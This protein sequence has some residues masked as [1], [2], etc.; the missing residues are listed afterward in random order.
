MTAIASGGDGRRYRAQRTDIAGYAR[1]LR[2]RIVW[3]LLPVLVLGL[4]VVLLALVGPT[5][6]LSQY[7]ATARVIRDTTT[8]EAAVLPRIDIDLGFDRGQVLS[9]VSLAESDAVLNQVAQHPDVS[10]ADLQDGS[11]AIDEDSFAEVLTFT[12]RADTA[13]QAALI[14]NTWAEAYVDLKQMTARQAIDDVLAELDVELTELRAERSRITQRLTPLEAELEETVDPLEQSRL[15]TALDSETRTIAADVAVVD[16]RI[17]S[18]L[19]STDR[20]ALSGEFAVAA[21]TFQ[22]AQE[23][24]RPATLSIWQLLLL[25]TLA[26]LLIGIPLARAADRRDRSIRRPEDLER[27][28][29]AVLGQLPTAPGRVTSNQN[30]FTSDRSRPVSPYAAGVHK[31]WASLRPMIA[32]HGLTTVLITSVDSGHGSSTLA[33]NLGLVASRGGQKV[34]VVATDYVGPARVDP[35]TDL[36]QLRAGADLLLLDAAAL[37]STAAT[38]ALSAHVDGVILVVA[39][40]QT[41]GSRFTDAVDE[42]RRAG[43]TVLGAV[44]NRVASIRPSTTEIQRAEP[45]APRA[46]HS[47]GDDSQPNV[48]LTADDP[49]P[50]TANPDETRSD[51]DQVFKE[52]LESVRSPRD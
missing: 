45:L 48:D 8:A 43:G 2:R 23:P 40:G 12:T 17:S 50:E 29:V 18:N 3:L 47:E 30:M 5:Q 1:L 16:T 26:G 15:Q 35:G 34:T 46:G 41:D 33:A 20:L 19:E 7:E 6:Y 42:I 37:S 49:S 24:T 14:A 13:S 28:G 25:S 9:E 10:L 39:A 44:I 27:L 22:S 51:V 52:I 4:A 36:D 32:D 21:M 11:V 38:V 31:A